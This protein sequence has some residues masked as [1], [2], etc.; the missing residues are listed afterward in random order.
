M[1]E[2]TTPDGNAPSGAPNAGGAPN[3]ATPNAPTGSA[4]VQEAANAVGSNQVQQKV[5]AEQEKG[6]R[7]TKV[8]PL[9]NEAYTVAGVT[10]KPAPRNPDAP[11]ANA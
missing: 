8:D 11:I 9:P 7:G 2:D 4:Q 3:P 6:F 1:N 10:K 5:D